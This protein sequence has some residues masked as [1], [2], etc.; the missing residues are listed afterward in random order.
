MMKTL[1]ISA[2]ILAAPA[3]AQVAAPSQMPADPVAAQPPAPVDPADPAAAPDAPGGRGAAPDAAA[4]V[5][6]P[7]VDPGDVAPGEAV[8]AQTGEAGRNSAD[9]VAQV[10][11]ADFGTY[12][13]DGDG[14]LTQAEFVAWMTALRSRQ[15]DAGAG[16]EGWADQAFAQADTDRDGAI[17]RDELTVFLQ[18]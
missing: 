9:L 14:R 7:A 4:A 1:M 5:T 2:L 17:S 13:A 11:D 16:S 10:V 6:D 18:G 8:T 15:S 3:A 12:D